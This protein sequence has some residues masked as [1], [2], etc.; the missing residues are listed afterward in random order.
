MA[1]NLWRRLPRYLSLSKLLITDTKD[2]V[3]F[4]ANC[5]RPY[6]L[7]ILFATLLTTMVASDINAMMKNVPL[8]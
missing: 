6:T 2:F 3:T 7:A 5:Q 4:R 1:S 8:K